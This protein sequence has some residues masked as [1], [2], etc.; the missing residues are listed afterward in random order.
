[1]PASSGN[2][3]PVGTGSCPTLLGNGWS[4][5][6][7]KSEAILGRI[8]SG[9]PTNDQPSI[10]VQLGMDKTISRVHA[11]VEQDPSGQ[12][13]LVCLGL[14]G[15][16]V[17][18]LNFR[19]P[20]NPVAW[21]R[22]GYTD[23]LIIRSHRDR[24]VVYIGNQ[25]FVFSSPNTHLPQLVSTSGR[26]TPDENKSIT[27]NNVPFNSMCDCTTKQAF[28]EPALP[29]NVREESDLSS[30]KKPSVSYAT[31]I[32][33]AIVNAPERKLTLAGIYASISSKYSYYQTV[34]SGWQVFTS[35]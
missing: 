26:N 23:Y 28:Q 17:G 18:A 25:S 14:N 32:T 33:E 27:E 22:N 10:D 29:V 35:T 30:N 31:M 20:E 3:S 13:K 34:Y 9:L 21:L 11:K 2:A 15:V 12:W 16:K 19:A 4:Y 7:N 1:M 5:V 8:P 6:L 24:D